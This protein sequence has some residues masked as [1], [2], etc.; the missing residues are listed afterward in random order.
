MGHISDYAACLV[1][2]F[3]KKTSREAIDSERMTSMEVFSRIGR[4]VKL[5]FLTLSGHISYNI[6]KLIMQGDLLKFELER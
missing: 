1:D 4:E 3:L 2:A 6:C 5:Y